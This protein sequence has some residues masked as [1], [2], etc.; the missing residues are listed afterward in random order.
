[1][2]AL[3]AEF[4]EPE[5]ATNRRGAGRRRL[6]LV[7]R[8]AYARSSKEVLILDLSTTGLMFE[9]SAPLS[10]GEVIEVELPE[11]GPIAARIIWQREAY[12]GCEFLTPAPVAAISA[13]LL[14][15]APKQ[16]GISTVAAGNKAS[17]GTPPRTAGEQVNPSLALLVL[18]L[19]LVAVGTF[20]L[21]LLTLPFSTH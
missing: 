11:T 21:V 4:S 10:S 19:L 12:Y 8:A 15:S 6:R 20:M 2:A 17:G 14:R 3:W 1:M 16:D 18:F 7:A 9:T 5:E 13:A